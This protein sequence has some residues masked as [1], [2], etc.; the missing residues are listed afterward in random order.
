MKSQIVLAVIILN[1]AAVGETLLNAVIVN[2]SDQRDENCGVRFK[3]NGV[4]VCSKSVQDGAVQ[5][6]SNN[7]IA[8]RPCYCLYYDEKLNSSIVGHC[9][10]T[11]YSNMRLKITNTT[12]LN[13]AVCKVHSISIAKHI[14]SKRINRIGRFC[15]SCDEDHGLAVYSYHYISCV[16]CKNYGYKNWLKYFAIALFPLTIFYVLALLLKINVTSS[17]SS[18]ILVI[19]QCTIMPV[20]MIILEGQMALKFMTNTQLVVIKMFL[21]LLCTTNLD[22]FRLLYS[23]FCLHPNLNILHIM[24]LDYI[25]ALYPF[26]LILITYVLVT[27]YDRNYRLLVWIWKPFKWCIY[28]YSKHWNIRTSLIE[29]FATFILLSYIKILGVSLHLLLMTRTF[30]INKKEMKK[31]YLLMDASIEYFGSEHLPFA[32]LALLVITVFVLLPFLLLLLYPCR[33]FQRCLNYLGLRCQTLHIFMDAFQ[34]SYRTEPRDYRYFSA[35]YLLLRMLVMVQVQI[36]T[37]AFLFYTSAMITLL[38][39][40][41]LAAFQPYKVIAHNYRDLILLILMGCYFASYGTSEFLTL[42]GYYSEVSIVLGF[43]AI[44]IGLTTLYLILVVA[45]KLFGSQVKLIIQKGQQIWSVLCNQKHTEFS[46]SIESFDRDS[47]IS[48]SQRNYPPLLGSQRN[49]CT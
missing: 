40:V 43:T 36:F 3:D 49:T 21:T 17:S 15:G 32:V 42:L 11:C 14:H 4:C 1:V 30:N 22:F 19:C 24:S 26:L 29:T 48:D 9:L 39:A 20:F 31:N 8:I 38:F 25:V 45:S 12:N 28:H 44:I 23:P 33:C 41:V 10:F 34:G 37:S 2:E 5:C 18:G 16:K 13:H 46:Q 7:T 47:P 27:L 6:H 35:F